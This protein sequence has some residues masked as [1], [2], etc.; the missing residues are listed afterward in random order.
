MALLKTNSLESFIQKKLAILC[1][2][3]LLLSGCISWLLTIKWQ[4]IVIIELVLFTI[5]FG[6]TLSIKQRVMRSFTRA[7]LHLDAITQED[8][9][10]FGKSTFPKGKVSEFHQQLKQLSEKLQTQKS[11]YDQQA[12]LVYQLISQ[13]DTP[14]LIFNEKQQL[15]LGNEAFY[16]LFKQPWQMF[17]H[18]TADLLGLH[19]NDGHWKFIEQAKQNRWQIRH[20]EFI[21]DGENHQLL[22]F[23]D[24]EPALRE[25]QLNAWQ[26]IIRVL[27]HEIRNSLTPVSSM[28]ETLADKASNERDKMVLGVIT[29]RCL[30][31]QSFVNR[32]S[33][34]SQKLQ[35]NCQWLSVEHVIRSVSG[36]FTDIN[37]T[38]NARV[39]E[40][41]ADGE[42]I[43]QIF[44]NL[45]KNAKEAGATEIAVSLTL[46]DQYYIIEITDDGHG[47]S[48][49]NNLFVPLYSTKPQ[50]Q[51]I[52]LSFCRNII[53]Q[54][55]GV[56]ELHNNNESDQPQQGVT[57]M[58]ILPKPNINRS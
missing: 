6:F 42:F 54:H 58:M 34:L 27:G 46:E 53:E 31:L 33:S 14:V 41:W 10:Q 37:I 32:Y 51:G 19:Y 21:D 43:E 44:I 26:Q 1:T 40:F 36:L 20:S 12:F 24:I 16:Y 52:G 39:N 25:S 3:I 49:M 11:H 2:V 38:L 29:E 4:W 9:N 55:H 13:L 23:I 45:F 18:A 22:L 47:F 48:N 7:S 28:A 5:C 15:T 57:V 50:G 56:M 35:I 8:Y 17:R 30:H